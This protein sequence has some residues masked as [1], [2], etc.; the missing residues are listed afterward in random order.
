M[1]T[2][3][4]YYRQVLVSNQNEMRCRSFIGNIL[5]PTF[6]P[7]TLCFIV[8]PTVT[9]ATP[10]VASTRILDFYGLPPLCIKSFVIAI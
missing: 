8:P 4:K 2:G 6:I 5:L 1:A 10:I 3:K 9:A 7:K